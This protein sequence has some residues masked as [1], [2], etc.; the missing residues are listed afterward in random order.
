MIED[1]ILK[2]FALID[3][4]VELY[5]GTIIKPFLSLHETFY[6]ALNKTLRKILNDNRAKIPEWFTANW[7]TYSRTVLVVPT[8]LLLSWG[9]TFLP[10][11]LVIFVDFGDF[12]DGVVARFWLDVRNEIEKKLSE[13]EKT[14]PTSNSDDESYEVV[15]TGSPQNFSS[16]LILQRNRTYGGF[17]DAVCDKAFVVPCWISILHLVQ[18]SNHLRWLQYTVLLFLSLAEVASGCIRFRAY[19]TSVAVPAPKV[20]GFNFSTS[21]V[22]ADHVGKAK[23]TFEMVGTALFILPWCRYLGLVFL[24]LAVPLA[25]ESVRR[26]ITK[27]VLYVN[28]G[29]KLDML[30]HK[31]L[32]FWMQA[33]AM[34]SKLVVGFP[35]EDN[36]DNKKAEMGKIFNALACSCVDEAV[37]EAPEKLDLMFLEKQNIDFVISK[38]S[39]SQFV[40]DEVVNAGRYLQIG[41]DGVVR[42]FRLKDAKKD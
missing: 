36:N 23:Q 5:L 30:D 22:K 27:R 17:V 31:T 10:S 15:T 2:L 6:S 25:Y 12:L 9:Y 3:S 11:S 39:E 35:E 32:K 16:W 1:T 28:A 19:F 42:L 8:I 38:S 34:S 41:D 24:L 29:R 14:L 13:K 20:E 7:I 33:R 26:K 40:T 4:V 21:A 37:A 18:D